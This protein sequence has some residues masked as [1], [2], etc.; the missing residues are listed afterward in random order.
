MAIIEEAHD[1]ET[2]ISLLAHDVKTDIV[3]CEGH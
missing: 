2:L 1:N 3:K